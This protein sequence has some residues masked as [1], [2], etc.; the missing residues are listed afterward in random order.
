MADIPRYTIPDVGGI[1]PRKLY[2]GTKKRSKEP[3]FIENTGRDSAANIFFTTGVCW[4]A[5]FN[6]GGAYGSVEGT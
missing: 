2:G 6:A 3:D 4:L 5:A 1:D